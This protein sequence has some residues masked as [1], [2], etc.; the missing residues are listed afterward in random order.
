M[1]GRHPEPTC[2]GWML[3]R[4]R[5]GQK[6]GVYPR[7]KQGWGP[8]AGRGVPKDRWGRDG[9]ALRAGVKALFP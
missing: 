6:W 9:K 4:G 5:R 3:R 1:V 8:W 2:A 7:A